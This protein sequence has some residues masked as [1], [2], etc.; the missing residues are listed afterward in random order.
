MAQWE[1]Q[2]QR[3]S[4]R[5]GPVGQHVG[6]SALRRRRSSSLS[7]SQACSISSRIASSLRD[8]SPECRQR[9][10]RR[11]DS[12]DRYDSRA[13]V[14]GSRW[15]CRARPAAPRE[16]GVEPATCFEPEDS[17]SARLAV[18]V[19]DVLEATRLAP[20]PELD[21]LVHAGNPRASAR[22]APSC[23]ATT[24]LTP[25]A[26]TRRRHRRSL[27]DPSDAGSPSCR[28]RRH[29]TR[30]LDHVQPLPG[31]VAPGRPRAQRLLV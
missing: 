6:P 27:G 17:L 30:A 14:T 22:R 20:D 19:L 31:A 28:S 16:G 24:L 23:G 12:S 9:V 11:R 29:Y 2:R 4:W 1:T 13:S 3:G 5:E 18:L 25:R 26:C 8:S 10:S 21:V 7:F 15:L